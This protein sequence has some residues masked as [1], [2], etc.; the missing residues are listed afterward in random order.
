MLSVRVCVSVLKVSN[1]NQFA[2]RASFHSI[3]S[4]PIFAALDCGSILVD[5]SFSITFHCGSNSGN[6]G[7]DYKK[8][9]ISVAAAAIAIKVYNA[10][11]D[12]PNITV[13]TD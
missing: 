9:P 4:Q 8:L 6:T 2:S 13:G 7:S 5:T 12:N 1:P 10:L 3:I 11:V